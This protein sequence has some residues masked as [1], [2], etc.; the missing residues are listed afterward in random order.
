MQSIGIKKGDRVAAYTPNTSETV[1]A[2]IS[3][4]ALGKPSCGLDCLNDN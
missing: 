4:A 1:M 2:Y 3:T